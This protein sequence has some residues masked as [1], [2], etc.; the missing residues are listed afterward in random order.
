MFVFGKDYIKDV[1]FWKFDSV[2][3]GIFV[4]GVMNLS[5]E[6]FILGCEEGVVIK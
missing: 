6:N 4:F 2:F 1:V 5:R 3:L